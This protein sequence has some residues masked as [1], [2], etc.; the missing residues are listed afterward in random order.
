MGWIVWEMARWGYY[1][2]A[3]VRVRMGGDGGA[4]LSVMKVLSSI[5]LER[6]VGT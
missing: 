4:R 2:G 5:T 1:H 6:S 3:F